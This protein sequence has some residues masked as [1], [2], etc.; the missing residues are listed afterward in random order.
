MYCSKASCTVDRCDTLSCG[1][2]RLFFFNASFSTALLVVAMNGSDG[3]VE[4]EK[5]LAKEVELV[6]GNVKGKG[7][8]AT[9]ERLSYDAWS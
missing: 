3:C 5:L 4:L 8:V 1:D 6:V 9:V 2:R 7:M